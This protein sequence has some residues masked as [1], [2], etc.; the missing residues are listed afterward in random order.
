MVLPEIKI[1]PPGVDIQVPGYRTG[2]NT[3][4]RRSNQTPEGPGNPMPLLVS[5]FQGVRQGIKTWLPHSTPAIDNYQGI[6]EHMKT[7][8]P[9]NLPPGVYPGNLIDEW[10]NPNRIKTVG[11]K[12]TGSTGYPNHI[13]YPAGYSIPGPQ[14]VKQIGYGIEQ[15]ITMPIQ[16][17]VPNNVY[18]DTYGK[19]KMSYDGAST[20]LI[21][22][23]VGFIAG[24]L[25]FTATGNPAI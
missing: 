23:I 5:E 14:P 7:K 13:D 2:V 24:A 6:S 20:F 19:R 15:H 11:T 1:T 17:I 12:I 16:Q 10:P 22:G 21:G 3:A 8:I 4:P 9:T 18:P 25:I